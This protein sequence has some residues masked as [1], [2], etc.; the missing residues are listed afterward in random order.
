M[1]IIVLVVIFNQRNTNCKL[2]VLRYLYIPFKQK[3]VSLG[4]VG[5]P[6]TGSGSCSPFGLNVVADRQIAVIVRRDM[7]GQRLPVADF[8][9]LYCILNQHL[10]RH[11]RE[12][13]FFVGIAYLYV[14]L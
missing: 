11:W 6:D 9:V 7:N 13:I 2:S 14:E 12:E 8:V 5:K 1:V 3:P 10:H 4:K